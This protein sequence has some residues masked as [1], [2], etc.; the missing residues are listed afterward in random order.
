MLLNQF[1]GWYIARE[2]LPIS[3]TFFI[4]PWWLMLS[5]LIFAA[6]VGI[7]A[8]LYPAGRAARLDPLVALRYE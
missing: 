1:I 6:L 5:A 7:V 4:T 3:G 2:A 8:G